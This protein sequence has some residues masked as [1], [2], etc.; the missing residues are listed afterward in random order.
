MGAKGVR[1]DCTS[2]P[3]RPIY[4]SLR[5]CF[6]VG[7]TQA[8]A[9]MR[10]VCPTVGTASHHLCIVRAQRKLY[11]IFGRG[12]RERVLATVT[13]SKPVHLAAISRHLKTAETLIIHAVKYFERCGIFVVSRRTSGR[14]YVALNISSPVSAAMQRMGESLAT[15]WNIKPIPAAHHRLGLWRKT[16]TSLKNL[17]DLL[18]SRT[19]TKIL[20]L[21]AACGEID[22]A[23]LF[24][25]LDIDEAVTSVI[26]RRLVRQRIIRRRKDW[27]Y[28]PASLNSD[29]PLAAEIRHLL[30]SMLRVRPEYRAKAALLRR[31]NPEIKPRSAFRGHRS[32]MTQAALRLSIFHPSQA[33]A[34]VIIASRG[35]IRRADLRREIG[36]TDGV[37]ASTVRTLLAA[38]LIVEKPHQGRN[39]VER[40]FELDM[41]HPCANELK[42][43]IATICRT[44]RLH[45]K[46]RKNRVARRRRGIKWPPDHRRRAALALSLAIEGPADVS[47]LARSCNMLRREVRPRLAVL[48]SAKAIRTERRGRKLWATLETQSPVGVKL[49]ALLKAMRKAGLQPDGIRTMG[50]SVSGRH[51]T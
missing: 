27:K 36:G 5:R 37:V 46:P 30:E 34:L 47:M 22:G 13:L 15:I 8:P 20:L 19:Q 11:N 10:L 41:E 51:L 7:S 24:R 44:V 4:L 42:A 2:Q 1:A 18:V 29:H 45:F 31:S 49:L 25:E 26:L 32:K 14:T 50:A 17:D 23:D 33:R 35:R 43:L 28:K 12:L 40:S 9:A 3:S 39:I 38:G 16:R 6:L 48:E 21:I